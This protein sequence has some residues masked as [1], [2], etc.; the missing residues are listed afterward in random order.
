MSNKAF[1][2]YYASTSTGPWTL[3]NNSP[4]LYSS[5]SNY[6]YTISNLQ[7]KAVYY[8]KIIPGELI[9]D[10]FYPLVN[11]SIGNS[12]STTTAGFNN[13]DYFVCRTL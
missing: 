10:E 2:I 13:N 4:I 8:I 11:E 7:S 1:N 6:G 3:A 12:E 9:D 5:T